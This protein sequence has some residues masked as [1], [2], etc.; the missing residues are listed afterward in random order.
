MQKYDIENYSL[1]FI[2]IITPL[3]RLPSRKLALGINKYPLKDPTY[4]VVSTFSVH[5]SPGYEV[6]RGGSY[7]LDIVGV[8][9]D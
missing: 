1:T 6:R 4:P 5:S 8:K 3:G 2:T 7:C 9:M